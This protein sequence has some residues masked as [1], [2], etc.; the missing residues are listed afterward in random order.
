MAILTSGT[1]KVL[2]FIPLTL[3]GW[4]YYSRYHRNLYKLL[5]YSTVTLISIAL[6]Y[7]IVL[8]NNLLYESIGYRVQNV[9][10]YLFVSK[11]L[12]TIDG[13]MNMRF[14]LIDRAMEAFSQRPYF[15]WGL[16]NFSSV[17]NSGG[18]YTHNNFLEILVSG[19]VIGFILYYMKYIYV[20]FSLFSI[21]K[22]ANMNCKIQ[23]DILL[24]LTFG[25]TFLEYWQITY[26]TRKFMIV[27]I[28]ILAFIK[29][30]KQ[31]TKIAKLQEEGAG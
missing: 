8:N 16:D 3:L 29:S 1:R 28:L 14:L 25:I 22:H 4:F 19:G 11:N 17:I 9:V 24:L 6:G 7:F 27:W 30:I 5:K 31:K 2:L 21:R 20:I 15:G 10:E 23:I 12:A 13:S 18:Y 26:F